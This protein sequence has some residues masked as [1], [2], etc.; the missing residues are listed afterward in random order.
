MSFF[1]FPFPP[2]L[3]WQSERSLFCLLRSSSFLPFSL[4]FSTSFIAVKASLVFMYFCAFKSISTIIFGGFFASETTNSLDFNLTLKVVS[5]T[6]SSASSTSKFLEWNASRTT[7][8]S[9]SFLVWWWV[10]GLLASSGA[11]L[12]RSG[13]ERNC[14][15][16]QSYR[17]MM[18]VTSWTTP[19]QLL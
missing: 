14:P 9:S 12:R 10:S 2:L 6:L 4:V 16:A 13:V 1:I 11:G 7:L 17:W 18:L 3:V 19:L 8:G 15:T 5:C